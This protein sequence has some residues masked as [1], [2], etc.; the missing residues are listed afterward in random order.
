MLR[1]VDVDD[2]APA[3]QSYTE[4]PAVP[5]LAGLVSSVWIQQVPPDADPYTHR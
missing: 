5:A 4:R 3:G 1:T 2:P